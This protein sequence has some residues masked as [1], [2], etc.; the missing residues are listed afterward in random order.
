[1]P[2]SM[3]A[4]TRRELG[5]LL[6]LG[7]GA[8]PLRLLAATSLDETL[9]SW[10]RRINIPAVVAMAATADKVTY[11]GAFGKRDG[12]SGIDVAS[13]SIVRIASMTKAITTTAAMQLVEQGEGQP[14][15][16][17][18]EISA[19][20]GQTR[21]ARRFRQYLG[22]ADPAPGQAAG[23]IA[24]PAHSHFWVRIPGVG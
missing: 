16:A 5:G 11:T 12:S 10:A 14:H 23:G 4:I 6:L 13:D 9:A 22:K 1:M 7:H 18:R 8:K 21:R 19:R 24:A 3:P 20:V 2:K 15:R 17:G